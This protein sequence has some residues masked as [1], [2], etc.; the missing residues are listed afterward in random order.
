L[1]DPILIWGAGAIGGTLGAAFARRGHEVVF[2]DGASDHVTAINESGLRITGPI[3]ED[4]V[5]AHAYEPCSIKGKFRRIFLCV[6]ALHTQQ[7]AEALKPFLSDDGHV[8][9]AQN[10][11]NETILAE[12]LGPQRTVGC[13]VNFG[14]DYLEPGIVQ[15]SG[16]GSV[17]VGEIDNTVSARAVEIHR[18]L[19]DFEPNARITDNIWGFLWGKLTYGAILFATALTNDSIADILAAQQFRKVLTSLAREVAAVATAEGIRLE[20]FDG[21]EPAAFMP[22]AAPESINRSF[23]DMVA[24]NRRSTKSHSGI[25]RDLAIR[26]RRTECE[27][28]LRPIV[29]AGRR[30]GLST[31]LTERLIS[32]I[33][34]IEEG[35]RS[36]SPDNIIL[37]EEVRVGA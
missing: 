16:R 18:L 20:A 14:A 15:Y 6:K 5:H 29:E 34:E 36:F 17:V 27:P 1:S 35:T 30:L 22:G 25:W 33:H 13:F 19:Q 2:V 24:Q 23:T 21:F 37:L 31:P 12:I 4:T 28:Q 9:S 8:I 10:G 7:A 26:K 11:L 3:F 32:F